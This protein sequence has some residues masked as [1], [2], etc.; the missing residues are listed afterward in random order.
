MKVIS[1]EIRLNLFS[2]IYHYREL[3]YNL[4]LR[5]IKARAKQSF[6]GYAWM[7]IPPIFQMVIFSILFQGILGLRLSGEI[8]YPLFLYCTLVPWQFFMEGTR[9][10]TVSIVNN[11]GLIRQIYF[12]KEVLILSSI[13]GKLFDFTISI[14]IL[15]GLMIFYKM[16]IHLTILYIPFLVVIQ[17]IFMIGLSLFLSSINTYYRDIGVAIPLL[18]QIWMY[19]SP[20]IYPLS[21]VPQKFLP[22]YQ[23]NPMVGII[24]G[25]RRV[26][27]EGISPQ[28]NLIFY[29]LIFSFVL[30]TLAYLYFKR[31]EPTFAD[32]V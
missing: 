5:D 9:T 15:I 30:L 7:V 16:S 31:L 26:I 12:P 22:L 20:I 18:M 10:A 13:A 21:K 8:P 2:N 29:C 4:T 14:F 27:I 11:A 23:I 3:I 32:I 6:L 17:I 25:Y 19:I 28:W 24:D 1:P